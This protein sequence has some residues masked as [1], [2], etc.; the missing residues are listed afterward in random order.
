MSSQLTPSKRPHEQSDS[1]PN[2]KGKLQK[3]AYF[4]SQNTSFKI[5][6]GSIVFRVLCA[7]S[8][9]GSVIGKG[10]NKISQIR[11]DTGAK[12][13]VEETVPGCN[14]RV[15]VIAGSGIEIGISTDQSK[16]ADEETKETQA[17]EETNDA[18]KPDGDSTQKQSVAGEDLQS[19]K[20]ASSVQKALLLVF[21]R[22]VEG[23]QEEPEMNGGDADP[24]KENTTI[25]VRLLVLSTQVGCLLGKSGG[26]I[27]QMASESGA[28][29]RIL[30]RDKLPLCASSSD[31]LVQIS[32][33]V[34]AVRK[35]LQ[36]VSQQLLDHPPRENDSF[37]AN[38]SGPRDGGSGTFGR[39]G[40]L[41]DMLTY[42]LICPDEKVGG[43]IGKGGTI[44]KALKHETGCDIKVLERTAESDDRV[45]VIS[46]PAHPDER[47][48]APQDAVLR[49]QTRIYRAAPENKAVTAKII[50]S[51]HQIGCLLGKGGAVISEMR[52]TTGAYIRILGKDQTPQYAAENEEVVQVNGDFDAV[53][54]ALLQI[55]T[56]LRNHFFRDAFPSMNHPSNP[57]FPDHGP[58]FPS[59]MGRRE[60]SPPGRYSS[61]NRFD[62]G[63]PPHGAFHP[64]D[65]CPPFMN[66]RPGF[67]H[68]MSERSS[69]PWGPQ[70]IEGR[71]GFGG[72][73][74]FSDY[75]GVPQRRMGGFGGGSHQAIITNTTVEVVVP[76]TVVPSIYGEDGGCLKQIRE[77]SDAKITITDPKPGAKETLIIISGTPEQAH[78][79]QSLIQAFVISESEGS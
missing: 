13:R 16:D 51:A 74:G 31:E 15:V 52:K 50:V 41:Q 6:P 71:G 72:P 10:G 44:V 79:A 55:T 29:I 69:A 53:H 60:H 25:V 59:Y 78:A 45:I 22:M 26:V 67:P 49:V 1:E 65:D 2:G 62:A 24:K 68:P 47:I 66:D 37:S 3:P 14:E 5:T 75:G 23:E 17:T 77:I 20:V 9:T 11:L 46:G 33:E 19:E 8:K 56:R 12:V 64:H 38:N 36:S 73:L 42:R 70:V 43:V 7:A 4:T 35:A 34:N 58:P 32:G 40:S 39:F 54:E 18:E 28:Q 63:P 48:C 57:G 61:F 21:E 76:R 27:K 30:P